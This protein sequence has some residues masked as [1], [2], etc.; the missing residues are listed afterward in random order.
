ME[1]EDED[2]NG[3]THTMRTRGRIQWRRKAVVIGAGHEED[4]GTPTGGS[5]GRRT[6]RR[7]KCRNG[8]GLRGLDDD[9]QR[10]GGTAP[11]SE[12]MAPD[13]GA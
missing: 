13:G 1:G 9:E 5:N 2:V 10:S 4:K 12:E 7:S 3:A 11:T 8:C 6:V